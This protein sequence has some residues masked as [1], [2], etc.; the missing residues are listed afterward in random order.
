MGE[1]REGTKRGG[2]SGTRNNGGLGVVEV[3]KGGLGGAGHRAGQASG[4]RLLG[5]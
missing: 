3:E 2:A 4:R 5:S 1:G